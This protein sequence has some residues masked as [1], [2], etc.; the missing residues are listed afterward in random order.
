[1]PFELEMFQHRSYQDGNLESLLGELERMGSSNHAHVRVVVVRGDSGT[2]RLL[3]GEVVVSPEDRSIVSMDLGDVR[4]ISEGV[5]LSDFVG[6]ARS[7]V[8]SGRFVCGGVGIAVEGVFGSW[9]MERYSSNNDFSCWP[10]LVARGVESK[11]RLPFVPLL[12]RVES[13]VVLYEGISDLVGSITFFRVFNG[14][15]DIR[16]NQFCVI[17]EDRRARI[18]R[19]FRDGDELVVEVQGELPKGLALAGCS[20]SQQGARS[21]FSR[22]AESEVRIPLDS[23]LSFALI[24]PSIVA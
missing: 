4:V 12:A 16:I 17:V 10:C 11:V 19:C 24:R 5:G 3:H 1:M 7:A 2:W 9:R 20:R 13:D 14:S 6:R 8:V 18:D 23:D 15:R 21:R 22:P